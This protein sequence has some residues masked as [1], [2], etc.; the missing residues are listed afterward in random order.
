[1]VVGELVANVLAAVGLARRHA[2]RGG[3]ELAAT[4]S[5]PRP[6]EGPIPAAG[7]YPTPTRRRRVC[8]RRDGIELLGARHQSDVAERLRCVADLPVRVGF[9][10]LDEQH[11]VVI[12]VEE[13]VEP[14]TGVV[15][16]TGSY[17]GVDEPQGAGE[18]RPLAAGQSGHVVHVGA[19]NASAG[20]PRRV[21]G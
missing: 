17:E 14:A 15:D 8:V 1:M 2:G 20:R 4:R 12:Q 3:P 21:R 6:P 7:G 11:D 5:V 9:V 19:G 10:L 18:E 16:A 13:P